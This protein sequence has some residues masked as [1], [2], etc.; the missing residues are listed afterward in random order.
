MAAM[1]AWLVAGVAVVSGCGSDASTG[2]GFEALT[3]GSGAGGA[4]SSSGVGGT[5]GASTTSGTGAGGTMGLGPPYPIVLSHG[6]FGFE[7][8]AGA[9]FLS[10]YYGVKDHLAEAGEADVFTPAVDPFNDSTFRGQ[11]LIEEIEALLAQ[12][13]HAKVNIIGHSQGGLDARVVASVRPDLVASVT[14]LQ[15]PHQGT[16]VADI[17]LLI[18]DDPALSSLLDFIVQAVGAPL[19]DEVGNQTSLAAALY[20]FS[21]PGITAFNQSY[22]DQAGVAYASIAGRSDWHPGGSA[23]DAPNAPSFIA[24]FDSELD[25]IDALFAIPEELLDGG[26]GNP[27]PNDGLV[28]VEDAKRGTFLGCLPADHMDMVGQLLGDEPG[29]LNDWDYLQFYV[30]LVGYLRDQGF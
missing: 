30:D 15:T 4:T 3:T 8:F 21:E 11:Q 28:R 27:Y 24:A 12:T 18:V 23:C 25:P 7:D 16:P 19:Y 13:G 17:A 1:A 5:G 14:T 20:E 2:P 29:L 22:P 6:F 10:Y 26:F 9:G